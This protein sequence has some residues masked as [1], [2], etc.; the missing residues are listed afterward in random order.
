MAR[1]PSVTAWIG[2]RIDRLNRSETHTV[3]PTAAI[4]ATIISRIES[5]AFSR[6]R[7]SIACHVFLIQTQ[8]LVRILPDLVE[9]RFQLLKVDAS[10]TL[11]RLRRKGEEALGRRQILIEEPTQ[12]V[13]ALL[14]AGY[15]DVAQ[16]DLQ[17]LLEEWQMLVELLATVV[18]P[19]VRR[20][21][22]AL[23]HT[24]DDLEKE[25]GIHTLD[26]L[27]HA[28]GRHDAPVIL[29]EDDVDVIA[30]PIEH[31]DRPETQRD[32]DRQGRQETDK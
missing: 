18:A 4:S 6:A 3:R 22:M 7:R 24:I 27:F 30:Q 16:L 20:E 23:I 11:R 25:A 31:D 10:P 5:E 1:A 2:L 13:G 29:P 15:G 9:G 12:L 8:H 21:G 14:F 17:M 26:R 32:Q 28:L 19:P